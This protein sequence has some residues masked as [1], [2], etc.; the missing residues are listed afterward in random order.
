ML[1]M[2]IGIEPQQHTSRLPDS[3]PIMDRFRNRKKDNDG[4]SSRSGG[5]ARQESYLPTLQALPGKTEFVSLLL[6]S[7]T[8]AALLV[9]TALR[10][11]GSPQQQQP[12]V[13]LLGSNRARS[14]TPQ[15]VAWCQAVASR[16]EQ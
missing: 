1:L 7:N 4:G 2:M 16:L 9:P 13:I 12:A 14:F 15:H 5:V 3:T 8:Q 10:N 11:G 6:P